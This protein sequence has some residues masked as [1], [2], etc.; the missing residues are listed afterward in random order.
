MSVM[1]GPLLVGAAEPALVTDFW[2]AALGAEARRR[3]LRVCTEQG[4]KTV[5]NRVHLDVAV[6]PGLEG[7]ERLVRLGARVLADHLPGW[8]TLADV[9]GNEFC[10]FPAEPVD[11]PPARVFAVC[12]DSDRP[13]ELA[14]WWAA[15]VGARI[16]PGPDRTPRWLYG[17]TG[18]EGIIWKFVRVDD[19][20]TGPN[21]WRW[22]VTARAD[23]LLAAGARL[24]PDG[25]LVDPQGNGFSAAEPTHPA[26]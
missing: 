8:V 17:C 6:G 18:W 9:E 25:T 11:G 19:P 24:L 15:R 12:T 2:S 26:G 14:A 4:P 21:R 7:V 1:M 22:S 20:R 5:K 10:A 13:E 3:L 16:G 23:D